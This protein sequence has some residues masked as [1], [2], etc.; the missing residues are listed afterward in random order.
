MS[1]INWDL[2]P[3]GA[4]EIQKDHDDVLYWVNGSGDYWDIGWRTSLHDGWKTIATRQ[5][6]YPPLTQSLLDEARS[7]PEWTHTY[8]GDRCRVLFDEPDKHGYMCVLREKSGYDAVRQDELKPI[9]PTISKA[10]AWDKLNSGEYFNAQYGLDQ[11][12]HDFDITN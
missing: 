9:K 8:C 4:I 3:E 11:I 7:E 2:A 10:E 6:E 1:D 5:P 12:K